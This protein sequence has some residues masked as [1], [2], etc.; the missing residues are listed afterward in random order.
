MTRPLQLRLDAARLDDLARIRS[1]V[2][3]GARSLGAS[4]QA[5]DDLVIAVDEAAT[6]VIRH[7]YGGSPGPIVVEVVREGGGVV[8]RLVDDAPVF[9]PTKRPSPDLD[10]P[11]ESRP[12]GGMGIHLMRVSVDRI[13]HRRV[14]RSGNDLTFFKDLVSQER[15]VAE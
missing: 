10:E 13:A 14:G 1:F 2:R 15:S 8:V 9:D 5:A 3:E 4:A 7:G 11:L 6:N 12:F